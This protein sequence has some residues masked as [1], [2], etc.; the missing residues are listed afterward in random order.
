MIESTIL[1]N[2]VSIGEGNAESHRKIWKRADI[3]CHETAKQT[4]NKLVEAG[5]IKRKQA[6][7]HGG[8]FCWVYWRED[9]GKPPLIS[10]QNS[11]A[12]HEY[13]GR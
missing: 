6:P 12:L 2:S 13:Q 10:E 11:S 1:L 8:G 7:W 5:A 9:S 4:L 3:G